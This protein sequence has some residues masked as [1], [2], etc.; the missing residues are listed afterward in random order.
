MGRPG[1]IVA[2]PSCLK[3]AGG[4]ASEPEP[5]VAFEFQPGTNF[6]GEDCIQGAGDQTASVD[7]YVDHVFGAPSKSET[8]RFHLH[9]IAVLG[10][11]TADLG[12]LPA[13]AREWAPLVGKDNL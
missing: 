12:F 2:I 8:P 1:D 4:G 10:L 5:V 13:A 9:V 11:S 3:P 6:A 7:P